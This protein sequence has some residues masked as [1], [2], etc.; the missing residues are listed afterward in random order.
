MRMLNGELRDPLRLSKFLLNS[1]LGRGV[2]LHHPARAL[3]IGKDLRN[4]LSHIRILKEET[5]EETDIPCTKI[6]IAAGAW[7][8]RVFSTLF[9]NAKENF[10]FQALQATRWLCNHQGGQMKMMTK[11]V[12]QCSQ[13]TRKAIRLRYSREQDPRFIS[14]G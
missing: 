10:L 11:V 12:M 3:S 4:E 6:L 13:Q 9:P 7:S 14:Q 2:Q 8:P 1:C 5:N